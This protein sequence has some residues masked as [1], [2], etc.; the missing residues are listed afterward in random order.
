VTFSPD[1]RW[2][3]VWIHDG[4]WLLWRTGSWEEGPLLQGSG[5]GFSGFAFSPDG[6][7]LAVNKGDTTV[8][9]VDM[10]PDRLGQELAVLEDPNQ[11]GARALAFSPDGCQLATG[12]EDSG[13]PHIWD[14][15]KIRAGLAQLDLDWEAEPLPPAADPAGPVTPL[16]IT[17]DRGDLPLDPDAALALYGTASLLQ[18]LHPY[19]HFQVGYAHYRLGNLDMAGAALDRALALDPAYAP[20]RYW[21]SWVAERLG[22]PDAALADAREAARLR[23]AD[24]AYQERVSLLQERARRLANSPTILVERGRGHARRGQWDKAAADFVT[25]I[26]MLPGEANPWSERSRLY[27]ELAQ[28][29]Q[30]WVKAVELFPVDAGLWLARGRSFARQGAW[31]KAADAYARAV[32]MAGADEKDE[33]MKH[34]YIESAGAQVLAGDTKGYRATCRTMLERFGRTKVPV[35]AYLVGRACIL[36]PDS[37]TDPLRAAQF[38]EQARRDKPP[39]RGHAAAYLHALGTAHYRAGQF[40]VAVERLG[41]SLAA[42]PTWIGTSLNWPVLALAHYRLGHFEE[43]RQ[44]LDRSS[45]WLDRIAAV[46]AKEALVFPRNINPADWLEF[47]VLHREAREL[48]RA[49]P[50]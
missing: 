14:L 35:T 23:P 42:D 19:A 15:R 45:Q 2:L 29:E 1:G 32:E 40:D 5:F 12:N 27:A 28:W 16:R 47:Q 25:A 13:H 31:Q 41:Q 24:P 34:V 50:K 36:A 10:R 11:D 3:L 22:K 33:D 43:A 20:A 17:V 6:Q 7:I 48:I 8:R 26:K 30:A 39:S 44:W 38:I 46:V 37:G 9:L 21:R 18:P 49:Q 4:I